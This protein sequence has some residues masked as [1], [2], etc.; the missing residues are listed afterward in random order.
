[1]AS[2][3][4]SGIF[5][6][7]THILKI[8]SEFLPISQNII[9]FYIYS[10]LP[11]GGI[12]MFYLCRE[13]RAERLVAALAALIWMYVPLSFRIHQFFWPMF[14]FPII[15]F[16]MIAAIKHFRCPTWG[17]V[18]SSFVL[19]VLLFTLPHPQY[20]LYASYLCVSLVGCLF[21]GKLHQQVRTKADR[22]AF[23]R[24]AGLASFPFV[25]AA[26]VVAPYVQSEIIFL[27]HTPRMQD[28]LVGAMIADAGDW[29][30]RFNSFMREA[31][32]D[33]F[34]AHLFLPMTA[35]GVLP[36]VVLAGAVI[37]YP[38][39]LG[40]WLF[41]FFF[42]WAFFSYLVFFGPPET[43]TPAWAAF[44]F[45]PGLVN[46]RIISRLL[47]VTVFSAAVAMAL[48]LTILEKKRLWRWLAV[49]LS[50]GYVVS[51]WVHIQ[52]AGA[53]DLRETYEE[54]TARYFRMPGFQWLYDLDLQ[55]ALIPIW[56]AVA[57]LVVCVWARTNRS[58]WMVAAVLV[59]VSLEGLSHGYS[60]YIRNSAGAWQVH[61]DGL[62][63]EGDPSEIRLWEQRSNQYGVN[64]SS[65]FPL[66]GGV[67]GSV[68]EAADRQSVRDLAYGLEDSIAFYYQ[69]W[70]TPLGILLNSENLPHGFLPRAY[71]AANHCRLNG[72]PGAFWTQESQ[73]FFSDLDT[74]WSSSGRPCRTAHSDDHDGQGAIQAVLDRLERSAHIVSASNNYLKVVVDSE[75]ADSVL[76]IN[77]AYYPAW[78]AYVDGERA[79]VVQTFGAFQGIA[80]GQGRHTVE[81]HYRPYGL[82]L[83]PFL[84]GASL[85]VFGIVGIRRRRL[86]SGGIVL[87]TGAYIVWF[88]GMSV[89][90]TSEMG[91]SAPAGDP[92]RPYVLVDGTLITADQMFGVSRIWNFSELLGEVRGRF[93]LENGHRYLIAS[94]GVKL[95]LEPAPVAR[96]VYLYASHS[97]GASQCEVTFH[98]PKAL[99]KQTVPCGSSSGGQWDRAF[100]VP[101][102]V[103]SVVIREMSSGRLPFSRV[104]LGSGV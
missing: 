8:L 44:E 102:E 38:K 11:L 30:V 66:R 37:S 7:P 10:M 40:N 22:R 93:A 15:P 65:V 12:G 67:Y 101:P 21:A 90:S 96:A 14:L 60:A 56:I 70:N 57:V 54:G 46:T 4:S 33:S 69:N 42:G 32:Y 73:R 19:S 47:L 97:G 91:A 104:A 78:E 17:T 59:L 76:Q 50:L 55:V 100:T 39:M 43:L 13:V 79:E 27:S 99:S 84:L 41:A 94:R 25:A 36:V 34:P 53:S 16:F 35:L 52:V 74:V 9:Q 95:H 1:M 88:G 80:V 85:L 98:T 72:E 2:D 81:M 51:L 75:S 61:L 92:V 3:P 64:W 63:A 83:Y 48:A 23:G 103:D 31:G 20:R 24:A 49:S 6:W 5:Y 89:V 28:A 87:V 18:V 62:S 58:P 77:A 29:L 45:G 68:T 86:I 82:L 71:V 26:L